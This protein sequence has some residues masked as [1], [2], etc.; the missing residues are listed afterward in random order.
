MLPAVT[1]VAG[2][3]PGTLTGLSHPGSPRCWRGR[4]NSQRGGAKR[5]VR[6][7]ASPAP[8]AWASSGGLGQEGTQAQ[9]DPRA[10]LWSWSV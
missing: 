8:G 2:T 1:S 7:Q 10:G 4:R 9:A 5:G 6:D 3:E